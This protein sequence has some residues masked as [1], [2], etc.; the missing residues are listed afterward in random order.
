MQLH[1]NATTCSPAVLILKVACNELYILLCTFFFLCKTHK[2]AFDM[3]V[4]LSFFH[5]VA[6][7]LLCG[8]VRVY[9]TSLRGV[10]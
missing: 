1:I 4:A 6:Y 9:L 2:R 3:S 5:R 8:C 10:F 7:F